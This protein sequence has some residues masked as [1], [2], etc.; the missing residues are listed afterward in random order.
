MP[1]EFVDSIKKKINKV[2]NA[3][4]YLFIKDAC[5]KALSG[6]NYEYKN[7]PELSYSAWLASEQV[8][9]G[10]ETARGK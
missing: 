1:A 4:D 6:N 2:P 7:Y 10:K 8:N 9:Q 3:A 5:I